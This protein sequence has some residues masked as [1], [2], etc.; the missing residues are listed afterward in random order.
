LRIPISGSSYKVINPYSALV[1]QLIP[2]LGLIIFWWLIDQIKSDNKFDFSLRTGTL[3]YP[4]DRVVYSIIY[5][6]FRILLVV[7]AVGIISFIDTSFRHPID[8]LLM[9]QLLGFLVSLFI[10]ASIYRNF[11][12]SQYISIRESPGF[13][14]MA[15]NIPILNF[16]AWVYSLFIFNRKRSTSEFR[17]GEFEPSGIVKYTK[18]AFIELG[19]NRGLKILL[20]AIVVSILFFQ[21]NS[22]GFELGDSRRPGAPLLFVILVS[23]IIHI[24]LLIWY[25]YNKNAYF[26]L[27]ILVAGYILLVAGMQKETLLKPFLATNLFNLVLF[28]GLFYFDE[29]KWKDEETLELEDNKNDLNEPVKL[30]DTIV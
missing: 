13:L 3:V 20:I 9:S 16:F 25:L 19:R 15:L 28:Y 11:L 17:D 18:D 2:V 4:L 30:D 12:V 14:Y 8:L 21:A 7:G 22:G 27:I 1:Y 10:I 29:L 6:V 23:G 5:W 24:S 26:A